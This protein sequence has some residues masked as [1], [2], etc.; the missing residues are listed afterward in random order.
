MTPHALNFA[1]ANVTGQALLM[2]SVDDLN[3]LRVEKI[4]HQE[5][6]LEALEMLKNLVRKES[7]L[8]RMSTIT[9]KFY[10]TVDLLLRQCVRIYSN[11]FKMAQLRTKKLCSS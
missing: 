2:L 1:A 6:I 10:A 5:I 8:D 4:G 3:R 7:L 9:R 11:G